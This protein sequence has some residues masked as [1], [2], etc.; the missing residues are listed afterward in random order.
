M[1]YPGEKR[2]TQEDEHGLGDLPH[3]HPE[4]GAVTEPE[5]FGKCLKVEPAKNGVRHNLEQGV[6][7][8]EHGGYFTVATGKVVPDEDHG[9]APSE[10][11]DDQ[12][13]AV[14][15]EI[16]QEDPRQDEHDERPDNPV[17]SQGGSEHPAIC[18][19]VAQLRVVHLRQ[20]R[21]HHGEQAESDRQGDGIDL[22][23]VEHVVQSRKT[24]SQEQAKAHRRQDPQWEKPVERRKL[25]S[26]VALR[27]RSRRR[28]RLKPSPRKLAR[29]STRRLAALV[30][31]VTVT[32]PLP[33]LASDRSSS[34]DAQAGR[35]RACR[36]SYALIRLALNASARVDHRPTVRVSR[37]PLVLRGVDSQAMHSRPSGSVDVALVLLRACK[38]QPLQSS[39]RPR[40]ENDRRRHGVAL[41]EG[42]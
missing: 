38:Q 10:A 13:G 11:D 36:P 28:H 14:A 39:M 9:D 25:S 35:C 6:E 4:D 20:N 2:N 40:V 12:A 15:G 18:R 41:A 21:V 26:D 8:D 17:Q 29:S 19:N 32:P 24:S 31:S 33:V 1:R 16:R 37:L 3:R 30:R 22:G 34:T 27:R 42:G 5:P 23:A 7:G